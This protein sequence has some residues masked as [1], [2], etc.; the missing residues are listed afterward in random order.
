MSRWKKGQSGNPKGRPKG[1]RDK[2]NKAFVDDF[3]DDWRKHGKEA[4]E[5]VREERPAEYLR[6][7]ASLV[8]KEAKMQVNV[9]NELDQALLELMRRPMEPKTIDGEAREI[10]EAPA[11]A[12]QP[13]SD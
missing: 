9:N 3:T 8:P 1:S 4:I 7:A 13:K 12:K 11:V 2:I 10:E 6:I 5:R